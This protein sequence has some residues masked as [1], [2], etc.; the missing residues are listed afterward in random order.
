MLR[1]RFCRE[2][3]APRVSSDLL[4]ELSE[5]AIFDFLVQNGD[6]HHLERFRLPRAALLLL[7]QC[8]RTRLF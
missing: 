6:R 1:R 5:A 3:L 2:W 4:R 7:G 8:L